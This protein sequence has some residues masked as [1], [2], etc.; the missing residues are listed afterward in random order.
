MKKILFNVF[1]VIGAVS[2]IGVI[3]GLGMYYTGRID[4]SADTPHSALVFSAIERVR[5][6]AIEQQARKIAVPIDLSDPDRVRRGAGNYAAMCVSCHLSPGVA[7]SEI[8]LGLYPTPPDL[9]KTDPDEQQVDVMAAQRF[10]VIK[11]GIKA[12]G[13]PAW[14]KGGMDE[15]AIWDMAAFL[16]R[17]PELSAEQYRTLVESSE[18]H[19]HGGMDGGHHHDEH[20]DHHDERSPAH[21]HESGEEHHSHD[22]HP[23]DH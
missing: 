23:H 17:L 18:G 14:S 19:V 13:M 11:H 8:R 12:S 9:T 22:V 6:K 5:D 20:G 7:N 4:V 21:Q 10:W 2:V 1:A 15:A 3:I 16:R